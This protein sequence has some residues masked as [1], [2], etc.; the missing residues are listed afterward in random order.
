MKDQS[1]HQ[2]LRTTAEFEQ[3]ISAAWESIPAVALL[4]SSA[5]FPLRLLYVATIHDACM[6]IALINV[7]GFV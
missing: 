1:Y 4:R 2:N 5:K 6:G 7:Y 3:K